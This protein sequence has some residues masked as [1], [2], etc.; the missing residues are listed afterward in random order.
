M[1]L[2]EIR[3]T[4]TFAWS[5][6][7]ELPL[8]ATG[9]VAGAL[10]ESFSDESQLEIWAPDFLDRDEFELGGA[11]QRGPKG[12]VKDTARFNRLAWGAVDA[13]RPRGVI[14]AGLENGELALWDPAKILATADDALIMRND[15][16]T[17]PIRGLDF[18]PIQTNLIAS[19][20][21]SGEVY[22]WDLNSP[23]KPYTPTPGARSTKLDEMTSVAWN[24]QVQYVLAGASNTGY[25]V[26][27]DLRG[28]REVV[29]LAYGGGGGSGGGMSDIKWHP[30]NATRL[31]TASEDDQSPI[32][33]MWDLRNA[34][35]PEKI[36]TGHEKGILSLSWCAQDA[37][38][39]LSCG[40][41]N[42][43]LCWNP[44]TGEALGELPRAQNWAFQ[45]DWCPR[46]PDLLAAAFFDGTI[47]VHSLQ[48]TNESAATADSEVA[49]HAASGADI[50][51]LQPGGTATS[52]TGTLSLA[53]P[54][55][56]FRRSVSASFGFGGK[57]VS[58]SNLPSAAGKHQSGSVHLRT[59]HVEEDVVERATSLRGALD[60][61]AATT[62]GERAVAAWAREQF[63]EGEA[64][65]GWKALLSLFKTDSREELVALL[66][67]EKAE[68]ERKVREAVEALALT[69]AGDATMKEEELEITAREAVVSFAEQEE[70]SE[71][72]PS[73]VSAATSVSVSGTS[74]TA[75]TASESESTTT[76]PSLFG[77]DNAGGADAAEADA[78]DFFST[79]V[80]HTNYQLD[81][82]VAA[83]VGSRPSS[84]ASETTKGAGA[85]NIY[86]ASASPTDRLITQA[87]VLG[88]FESA[89][90]LC[91]ASSRFA[92]AILL[93]VRG[94]PALLRRTQDAYF[95]STLAQQ[96][97]NGGSGR[98]LQA[99]VNADL[100]DVV[101]NADIKEW[102]EVFVV[103][104]TFAGREKGEFEGLVE[105]L[106]GRLEAQGRRV[107][108]EGDEADGKE[109]RKN[110]TLAYLAAGK[111]ERLVGIWSEQM[112]E[113]EAKGL[114]AGVG[115]GASVY[116]ARAR[117]LQTFVEKVTVFRAATGYVDADLAAT[118]EEK[119]YKLAA[120][121][122][123]YYEYAAVLA[124]QGLVDEAVRFLEL[125][126]AA[127][128]DSALKGRRERL[129][130]ASSKAPAPPPAPAAALPAVSARTTA[131]P[132]TRLPYNAYPAAV[133]PTHQPQ[134]PPA[135][136]ASAYN[137]PAGNANSGYQP[138][139]Q[140]GAYAPPAPAANAYNAPQ[141]PS[142]Y[143]PPGQTN[144]GYG[145][146]TA[147]T[148]LQ[149]TGP[150]YGQ[151]QGITPYGNGNGQMGG[152]QQ[153]HMQS[154]MAPPPRNASLANMA[155][156]PPPKQREKGGWNDAPIPNAS[157]A[158]PV[159]SL[160]PSAITAPFPNSMPASPGFNGPASPYLNQSQSIPPPPRPGSVQGP[161]PPRG[162][163]PQ[164]RPPSA[165]PPP[166]SRMMS[167][168]QGPPQGLTGG[169]PARMPT[170]SQYGPPPTRAPAPGEAPPPGQYAR[171]PVPGQQPPQGG[172]AR[173][174]PPP[175]QSPYGRAT[176]PLQPQQQQQQPGPYGPPPGSQ[177]Q[178]GA[179]GPAPG[180]QQQRPGPGGPP[181]PPGGPPAGGPPPPGAA[182]AARAP[183]GPP[184]PKYPPGDRSHIPETAQPAFTVISQQLSHMRE[185]TPPQQKR[186][187]DDLE[188]R[189]NPL[190]DA[191]NCETLS[192][193]VVEQ[194]V[195][196]A[197]AMEAHDRPAALAIHVDLLTRGSQT[198]DI[199]LWMSG[200]KQLIMRL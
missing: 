130:K 191:L 44:Q 62:D 111:L 141:Q 131:A 91:L 192:Q 183:K 157:R 169:G 103:L 137:P 195:V 50:F 36:L 152:S 176:P 13:A 86:P 14:A 177:Q 164:G 194:L 200:I 187:V 37:D 128:G 139:A 146:P 188:R 112:A 199:G 121:Y 80:P 32:I 78:S 9:T 122:E 119:T 135:M 160:K 153:P 77:D 136:Q 147:Y 132:A 118:S 38:L 127:F 126:P 123:R 2:K 31:V 114:E 90:S 167:P 95:A 35:A 6:S 117:A 120:L 45:V 42:R 76:A 49:A 54:P 105:E 22:I 79:V 104:C 198:D 145:R 46:N 107:V 162:M 175:G 24:R 12:I 115:S 179:Y 155:P 138:P 51:D 148:P 23:A 190:F 84:A 65:G 124:A 25:T 142:A 106:G 113:E 159:S 89:V 55:K 18:N 166:P 41:D 75:T 83:T 69:S 133:Q 7:A 8:L 116:S 99:V 40:K 193:P 26:V 108:E 57:L 11:G 3:R 71:K 109:W 60:K 174:A 67:F 165:A 88:D 21:V 163:P 59:V 97:G 56:W 34:R 172:F 156:P 53:H 73:E 20:A 87:L 182:A 43:T 70:G 102:R 68:I 161:P 143:N 168:P 17:G 129:V 66:G 39:L 171:P 170:P 134:Y 30:D 58:V 178:P 196:L 64:E 186:L 82:S 27:W 74:Q 96:G 189:I 28:K 33:M 16:H 144:A 92:D 149:T 151:S 1:K 100:T 180:S 101:R 52:A 15:T 29:A 93:A 185:T 125:T 85:F 4:S 154:Q 140:T 81:S 48:G 19:G 173:P 98:V 110:A 184:P 150:S 47:G 63:S 61:D 5:P 197:R 10:D 94:G 72:A 158:T 181:P